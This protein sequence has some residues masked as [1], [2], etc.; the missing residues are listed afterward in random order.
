[1]GC[2]SGL[3]RS[4]APAHVHAFGCY[5][6]LSFATFLFRTGRRETRMS[7]SSIYLVTS[8]SDRYTLYSSEYCSRSLIISIASLS[9]LGVSDA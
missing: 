7:R 3:H 4:H 5:T 9:F 2:T 6:S 1:M 8:Y